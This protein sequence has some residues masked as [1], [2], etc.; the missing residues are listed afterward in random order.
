MRYLPRDSKVK[1]VMHYPRFLKTRISVFPGRTVP[2]WLS[3]IPISALPSHLRDAMPDY[4]KSDEDYETWFPTF[5]ADM[6]SP[7]KKK[8]IMCKRFPSVSPPG[9]CGNCFFTL[10][11]AMM[12]M[13]LLQWASYFDP[14]RVKPIIRVLSRL[15]LVR[16]SVRLDQYFG[17][18]H[19]REHEFLIALN[20]LAGLKGSERI[21]DS[22]LYRS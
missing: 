12:S 9:F 14:K 22:T 21:D 11:Y 15:G 13:S 2:L 20:D 4:L 1:K 17:V 18:V 5:R 10:S 8:C 3:R 16:V 6:K 19:G 7:L